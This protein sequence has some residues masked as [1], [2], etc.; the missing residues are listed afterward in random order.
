VL[1][2]ATFLWEKSPQGFQLPSV[3]GA[4]EYGDEHVRRLGRMLARHLTI[5]YRFVCISDRDVPG[6][7]TLPLW[8]DLAELGGCYRRLKVFDPAFDMLGERFAMMDLDCVVTGSLDEMFSR[9]DAFV[10]NAYRSTRP[11]DP[12]QHYNGGLMLMTAG[13]RPQVW[14]QFD[15]VKTPALIAKR[16]RECIGTDQAW[17]RLCLGKGEARFTAGV[18]EFRQL[19]GT[20]PADAR[21]VMFAGARDPSTSLEIPWVRQHWQ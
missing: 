4:F 7:E 3:R 9:P 10:M 21:V 2:V 5:P 13:A 20:L 15:P 12:D 8:P 14:Q 16:R 19:R 1:T 11:R 17:I 6:V 18:Y